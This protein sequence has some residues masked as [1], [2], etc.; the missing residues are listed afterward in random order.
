MSWRGIPS[1]FVWRRL[2]SLSG[3][4]LSLYIILHL[5]T[6]AQA[7]VGDGS[8][9]VEEVNQIHRLPFLPLWELAG[10]GVPIVLHLVWGLHY[11]FTGKANSF[12][13]D[14]RT[15]YLDYGRNR[16]YTWQRVSAWILAVGLVAHV[17]HMRF[18]EYPERLGTGEYLRGAV[19]GDFGTI[20]LIML[21]ETFESPLMMALYTLLVLSGCYH[22]FNGLWTF[23]I[24][25]GVTLS[26]R[27]QRL[28]LRA[29]QGIMVG[30]ALLG[31]FAIFGRLL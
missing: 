2:H 29:C 28:W 14:G 20:T 18:L 27:A 25:W 12:R 16:A 9:F 4:W 19:V 17:V 24:K 23:M 26:E 6:N 13:S 22:G 21:K 30:V 31:L 1:D 10:L 7:A 11:L 5:W 8:G 15:P 3:L